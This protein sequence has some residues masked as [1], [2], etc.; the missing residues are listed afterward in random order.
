MKTLQSEFA[1][2][3][4][5]GHREE[6]QDCVGVFGGDDAALLVV[7]DGMGGHSDGAAA[8]RVTLETFEREFAD[9]GHPLLDP[10]GFLI[11]TLTLAHRNVVELGQGCAMDLR[12]RTTCAACLVQDDSAYW[13][14]V[15]DSRLYH[16]RAGAVH[17]RSRDHSKVELL[18]RQGLIE[19][20]EMREHPMR[21]V[22]ECCL[23]GEPRLPNMAITG[24]KKLESGDVI[25][26]CSDGLW[27]GAEDRLLGSL[28]DASAN[29]SETLE[30]LALQAVVTTAPFS[31]NTTAAALRWLGR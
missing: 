19:K 3:S 23:G 5:I 25:L 7:A 22:V 14:H 26:A 31:D 1:S 21:N 10:Q 17:E 15:G 12:P 2:I 28:S 11:S 18:Y 30:L 8:A 13:A 29:L 4:L 6:N 9:H 16:L 24:R 20:H 27:S